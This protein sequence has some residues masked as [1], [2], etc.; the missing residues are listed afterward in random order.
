MAGTAGAGSIIRGRR[1]RMRCAPVNLREDYDAQLGDTRNRRAG[2]RLGRAKPPGDRGAPAPP[3]ERQ[4]GM[5]TGS[6][7]RAD[8][9]RRTGPA[10]EAVYQFVP[11]LVPT[12]ER[13][14]RS[15]RFLLGD[16]LQT[17]ALDVLERLIEATYTRARLPHP[18]AANLGIE[19]LRVLCRLEGGPAAAH[20]LPADAGRARPDHRRLEPAGAGAP[21]LSGRRPVH[22]VRAPPRAADRQPDEPALLERLPRPLRPLRDR[23]AAGAVSALRGRLRA[24]RRRPGAAGGVARPRRAVPG[25]PAA[26]AA[27]GEETRRQRDDFMGSLRRRPPACAARFL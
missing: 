10:L 3:R 24:V 27:P 12:V 25:G 14:P 11:W 7:A 4:A 20:R 6:N 19:K 9:A 23:R 21:V 13:F 1:G 2:A 5:T 26:V 22:A 18:A 8:G 16:R 17:T 15:Q